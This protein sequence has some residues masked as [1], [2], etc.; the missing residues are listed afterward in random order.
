MLWDALKNFIKKILGGIYEVTRWLCWNILQHH[1]YIW[2]SHRGN[3]KGIHGKF[4]N[5][6]FMEIHE[7]SLWEYMKQSLFDLLRTSTKNFC[8][9]LWKNYLKKPSKNFLKDLYNSFWK[10]PWRAFCNN[11]INLK[12]LK[13]YLKQLLEELKGKNPK[14]KREIRAL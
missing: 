6:K 10:N 9:I 7:A 11:P 3:S 8:R 2:R 12:F 13:E 5:G 4:C 1:W 14:N